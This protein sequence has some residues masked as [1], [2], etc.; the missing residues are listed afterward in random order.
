MRQAIGRRTKIV[1][2]H[3][4]LRVVSICIASIALL[5]NASAQ[6]VAV[7]PIPHL[8]YRLVSDETFRIG[9][10]DDRK[11]Y[12][13][14]KP[15]DFSREN[16]EKLFDHLSETGSSK[17]MCAVI[18]TDENSLRRQLELGR[19]SGGCST[20]NRGSDT[21]DLIAKDSFSAF[22]SKNASH[23]YFEYTPLKNRPRRV[24]VTRRN[25]TKVYSDDAG[26]LIESIKDGNSIVTSRIIKAMPKGSFDYFDTAGHSPLIWAVWLHDDK[27]VKQLLERGANP[28]A[29]SASSAPLATAVSARNVSAIKLLLN[30][31]VDVN[32]KDRLEATPLMVAAI[33]CDREIFSILFEARA[34]QDLRNADGKTAMDYLQA[35]RTN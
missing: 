27:T 19:K 6:K 21:S 23:E 35:C 26:G 22:F 7:R 29:A 12:I 31:G 13:L 18:D 33:S 10:I 8:T 17:S 9:P 34:A 14:I 25:N 1:K 11:V 16:L 32:Q 28:N 24:L 30:S 3:L 20:A 15:E 5:V 2:L 4:I